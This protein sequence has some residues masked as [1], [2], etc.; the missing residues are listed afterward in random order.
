[1]LKFLGGVLVF[2]I[3]LLFRA[4]VFID[5]WEWFIVPF[6]VITIGMAHALGLS[7]FIG[8]MTADTSSDTDTKAITKQFII[9]YIS[10]AIVWAFGLLYVSLM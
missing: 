7:C 6:G 9:Q 1:M 4:I 8:W 2:I 10:T 5:L 3:L